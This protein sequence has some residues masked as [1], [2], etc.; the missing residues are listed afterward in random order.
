MVFE[1]CSG[2]KPVI[3]GI[4]MI[5][6]ITFVM[7]LSCAVALKNP[8]W[9]LEEQEEVL[10]PGLFHVSLYSS[11]EILAGI[12]WTS[13]GRFICFKRATTKGSTESGNSKVPFNTASALGV[14]AARPK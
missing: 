11:G 3:N 9:A 10:S 4:V 13:D 14:S 2:A 8:K 5:W 1:Y 6:A 7:N 12:S